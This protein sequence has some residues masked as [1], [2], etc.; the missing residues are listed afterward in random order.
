MKHIAKIGRRAFLGSAAAAAILPAPAVAQ[1]FPA[2]PIQLVVAYAPGGATDLVARVLAR[3]LGRRFNQP[4]TVDNR[5]GG[6]TLI[7]TQYVQRAAP[8]GLTLLFGTNALVNNSLMLPGRPYDA[9]TSFAPISMVSIQPLFAMVRPQLG[10]SNIRDFIALAKRRPG[11]LNFASSGNGSGQHIAGELFRQQAEIDIVHVPYRGA[12]PALNDLLAGQVDVMFTSLFG[13]T[14]HVADGRLLL[15]GSSGTARS[16]ATPN[17]P[18]IAE[19]GLPDYTHISWQGMLAPVGTPP[20][21][22]TALNQAIREIGATPAFAETLAAQALEVA[23]DTPEAMRAM[24][25]HE[26]DVVA[27]I[28]QATGIKIE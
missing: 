22:I 28:I 16:P 7:G 17:V 23:T 14:D 19:Q 11:A 24:L 27:R 10:V 21:I 6:G 18:T 13:L 5:P 4:V 25:V 20:A 1:A 15:L 9:V 2:R 12:G 8:D 26:R 3:D